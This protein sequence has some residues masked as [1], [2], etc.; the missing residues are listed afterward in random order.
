MNGT[1]VPVCSW[2]LLIPGLPYLLQADTWIRVAGFML[3]IPGA[4]LV[5]TH[6]LKTALDL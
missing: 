5:Y 6:V 1:V 2:L 4:I 3:A